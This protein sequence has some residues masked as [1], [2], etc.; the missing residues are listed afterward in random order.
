M[1]GGHLSAGPA[2]QDEFLVTAALPLGGGRAETPHQQDE[3]LEA[4]P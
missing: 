3:D 1:L 2:M 4:R